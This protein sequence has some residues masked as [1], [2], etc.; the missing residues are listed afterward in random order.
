VPYYTAGTG[1]GDYALLVRLAFDFHLNTP[2]YCTDADGDISYYILFSLDLSGQLR[3]N[4]DG[5]SYDYD[6]GG[7]FCTGSIN[8]DL[9]SGVPAGMA[10]VQA[11]L[12]VR[13]D[14]YASE[15]FDLV[16]LLPGSAE[17]SGTGSVNVNEHV[18]LALLPR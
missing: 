8:S 7:P 6:G 18:S 10:T 9:D 15:R 2:W 16:Y 17:T 1:R 11:Q 14:L 12:D 4:V 13:L 3:A 5:W